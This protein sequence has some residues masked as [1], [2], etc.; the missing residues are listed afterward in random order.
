MDMTGCNKITRT[1]TERYKR[2]PEHYMKNYKFIPA[3]L[4]SL[5]LL[6]SAG[7]DGENAEDFLVKNVVTRKLANGITVILLDRGYA[8]TL[9]FDM[10]FAVGSSDES[11]NTIGAAHLLEHMLFKGTDKIGTTDF[12]KE[13]ILLDKIE[14]VGETID[15]L[16][17]TN[18][19]N[20][21]LPGLESRL[22]ALQ[23]E[24]AQYVVSSP[25][26][27]IYS[28]KGGIGFNA[29]TSRDKTGY[30]IELP[31]SELELWAK[32]ESE[33][34]RHPVLREY[35][36]E[37]NNVMQERLM[38]Y[39]SSGT[40]LLSERF[41]ALA[42]EAHPY[43]H[44]IIGWQ[45]NIAN[46]SLRDVRSFYYRN[47]IPSRMVITV[48]GKQNVDDTFAVIRKYFET[49][50]AR[51]EPRK[52]SISEPEKRGE[53]RFVLNYESNPYLMIGWHKPTFP[54]RDDYVCDVIAEVLA[55]GMSSP[56]YRSIVIEK[57]FASS[58]DAWNGYPAARYDNL[59][60]ITVA[61]KA[62]VDTAALENEI[63]A[64]MEKAVKEVSRED[65]DRVINKMESDLV[66]GLA[67]N[68]GLAHMLSY[69]QTVFG[70]WQYAATY[71]RAIK[72]VTPE[73]MGSVFEKYFTPENRT[74]GV[75][76]DSRTR[77]AG[78]D[79]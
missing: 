8:P 4:L 52:T 24:A 51:P 18:P 68:K 28:E 36:L 64:K 31:S 60:L 76:I 44:P 58:I 13:K 39:D 19:E 65:L 12:D 10:S 14:A 35:Y 38:H 2:Y 74:V 33:R 43:R 34:L 5:I 56:L 50:K 59:F 63:Y 75:L 47:Y 11:Y 53:K 20:M 21:M 29:S 26:D 66:F 25:Y 41:L 15:H 46:L 45:S 69:Y 9:A 23:H 79:K 6:I 55:G 3:V 17:R 48:V 22:K 40:G 71:L 7:G 54:S 49:I 16:K 27:R 32:L 37:R 77:E 67:T 70:Q 1:F 72:S 42:F 57:Q 73:E 61:P 30:Y 62:G 78:H